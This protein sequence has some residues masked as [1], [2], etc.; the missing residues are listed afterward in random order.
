MWLLIDTIFI[1][2]NNA[3]F[4]LVMLL[5]IFLEMPNFRDEIPI[6][7]GEIKSAYIPSSFVWIANL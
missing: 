5:K 1:T 6:R 4:C 3:P 2:N 7:S